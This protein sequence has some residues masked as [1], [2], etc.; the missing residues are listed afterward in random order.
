MGGESITTTIPISVTI[1]ISISISVTVTVTAAVSISVTATV[2]ITVT[3]TAMVTTTIIP[4]TIFDT[5]HESGLYEQRGGRFHDITTMSDAAVIPTHC[6]CDH[7]YCYPTPVLLPLLPPLVHA[8]CL[9]RDSDQI[10]P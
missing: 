4:I 5:G 7:F 10:P 9:M 8:T 2:T 1:S 6:C 3:V